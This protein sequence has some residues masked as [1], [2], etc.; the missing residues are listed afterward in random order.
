MDHSPDADLVFKQDS[1]ALVDWPRALAAM[2]GAACPTGEP[3]ARA[4]Y[5]GKLCHRS[6]LT[7]APGNMAALLGI[8]SRPDAKMT[9]PLWLTRCS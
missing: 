3:P 1:D 8:E 9:V 6:V 4:L 7:L 2:L 5:V